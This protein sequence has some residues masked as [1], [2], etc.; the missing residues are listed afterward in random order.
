MSDLKCNTQDRDLNT[1]VVHS[2]KLF[3]W[4]SFFWVL[5]G[6]VPT[7]EPIYDITSAFS[8]WLSWG[9]SIIASCYYFF[10][11]RKISVA[12]KK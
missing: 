12:L 4:G 2:L 8:E 9:F 10:A 11:A 5:P 3:F 6:V 1:N 7:M